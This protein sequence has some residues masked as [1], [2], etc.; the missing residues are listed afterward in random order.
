MKESNVDFYADPD[1]AWWRVAH[2][3]E[4]GL[5][6]QRLTCKGEPNRLLASSGLGISFQ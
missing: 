4:A 6:M 5:S 2:L 3:A 1:G